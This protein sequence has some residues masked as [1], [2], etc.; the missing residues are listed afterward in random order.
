MDA[1][2]LM[3]IHAAKGLEF[4][5][6]FLANLGRG[7]GGGRDPIRV[8][9]VESDTGI[10]VSVG[11]FRSAADEDASDRDR[12]EVKRLLYVAVTRARDRLYLATTLDEKGRFAVMKGGLGEVMPAGLR[13]AL[14]VRE[15][16][17][18][19][20]R[21]DVI[22]WRGETAVHRFR[23]LTPADAPVRV[24]RQA[25]S[26]RT[27][28]AEPQDEPLENLPVADRRRISAAESGAPR[29]YGPA[30]PRTSRALGSLVHR[31][32]E[33]QEAVK[34]DDPKALEALA[35]RLLRGDDRRGAD[36]SAL[37]AAAARLVRGM[38]ENAAAKAALTGRRRWHE[39]PLVLHQDGVRWRGAADAIVEHEDG[40]VE[41][42]EFKTGKP[43]P[44]HELQL[45]LYL[46]A[47][48]ALLPGADVVGRL[49]YLQSPRTP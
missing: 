47:V 43:D 10:A 25:K 2:N 3:T 14:E 5:V 28:D 45:A 48:R 12:E 33:R 8:A 7:A 42:V 34:S 35:E 31:L 6:V 26:S 17:G 13:E 1:V 23:R 9:S 40:Q 21:R 20:V 30:D 27:V 49:V 37:A 11:T 38:A 15:S 29:T 24:A 41:V 22:E 46:T 18:P 19:S 39:V 36:P 32:L 16:V 4:P 44:A